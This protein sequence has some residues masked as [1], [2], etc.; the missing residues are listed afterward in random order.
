MRRLGL[1][2]VALVALLAIGAPY[3]AP[4]RPADM[5]GDR[6]FAPPTRVHV[7][8]RSGWHAP[9]VYKQILVD[10]LMQQ[11]GDDRSARVPLEWF[12][13]ERLVSVPMADGPLLWLG[14]D[15]LGR[16]IFSRLLFG[17]RLSLGVTVLGAIGA[18]LA[19]ALV[20]GLAGGAGGWPDTLLM[21]V[22]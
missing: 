20:G 7:H 22:A 5:F 16:D 1:W 14:A 4:N 10:R 15:D 3:V 21:F 12:S 6:N 19:G 2:I 18:L 13:H 9:F 11:Y 8:D 17:A